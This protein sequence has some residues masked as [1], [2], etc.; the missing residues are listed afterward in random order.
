MTSKYFFTLALTTSILIEVAFLLPTEAQSVPQKIEERIVTDFKTLLIGAPI[1]F[2]YNESHVGPDSSDG[3]SSVPGCPKSD[4]G[5]P[6]VYF[7]SPPKCYLAGEHGPCD[8]WNQKLFVKS[9]STFGFCSCTCIEGIE[10]NPLEDT[11]CKLSKNT[12]E[13]VHVGDLEKCFGIYDQGPCAENEW[14]VKAAENE[15]DTATRAFCEKRTC[16][17][18]AFPFE[19]DDGKQECHLHPPVTHAAPAFIAP[20]P[21]KESCKFHG[22]QYSK[23]RNR[24][25][26]RIRKLFIVG[27]VSK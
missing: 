1:D 25:V 9:G 15:A 17:F 16:P 4:E 3:L 14:I 10:L 12:M 27:M 5:Y 2:S 20:L 7:G 18:G 26:P 21:N 23:L 22:M 13:L 24:C 6:W 8:D 11:F 19:S